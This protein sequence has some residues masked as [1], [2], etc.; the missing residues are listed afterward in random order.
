MAVVLTA[1]DIVVV[2]FLNNYDGLD[3]TMNIWR[4]RHRSQSYSG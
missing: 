3:G 1:S 4:Y 2:N